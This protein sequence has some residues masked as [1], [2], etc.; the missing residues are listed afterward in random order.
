MLEAKANPSPIPSPSPIPKERE[1]SMGATRIAEDWQPSP[2]QVDALRRKLGADPTWAV[3]RFRNHFLAMA[4]ANKNAKKLR[5]DLAFANWAERDASAGK[6]PRWSPPAA[7]PLM[8]A[9]DPVE[10]AAARGAALEAMN[11]VKQKQAPFLF[12]ETPPPAAPSLPGAS[13]GKGA[14]GSDGPIAPRASSGQGGA[15]P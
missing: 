1:R 13:I 2:E 11:G 6:L 14:G 8:A 4:T 15:K 10:L 7:P 9:D 5:W 3:E 12:D